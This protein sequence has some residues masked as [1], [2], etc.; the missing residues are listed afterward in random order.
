[1]NTNHVRIEEPTTKRS[2]LARLADLVMHHRRIVAGVWIA[3]TIFGAFSA[4]QVSKRWLE[5]FSIPGFSAYEANQRALQTFGTGAQPP[6]IAVLRVKGDVTKSTAARETLARVSRDFP[7]FRTS[8][9]FTT[10]S[11]AYV[12]RDRHT[13]FATFYPPGRPS[14][15][16]DAGFDD[17][18]AALKKAALPGVETNV[19]GRDALYDSQGS[20][21]GGPS[22]LTEALIGGA[23]ALVIL[24]FV[25]GTLPAML[26]P[27]L[28]AIASILNT[29]TLIW[30]LTYITNVSIIVQ[31][32]VALVGLG[33]AIDYA[34]LMIF[35]FREEL[36]HGRD[37]ETAVVETMTHAGR[38]VIV[39]GSTVAI[40]LLS[41]VIIPIPVI[42]SIGIGGMLIP[43]VSVLVAITMLP[44]L[45]SLVGTRIN[46][47]RVMP[48][49]LVEGTDLEAGFWWRWA[50]LVM[51]R[52]LAIGAVG[53]A[54]VALLLIPSSQLNP[55]EAQAKDL[56]GAK[57]ADAVVGF[58]RLTESGVSPGALRPFDVLVEH[59]PG[60]QALRAVVSRLESTPGLAGASAPP[61]WR[62][63]DAALVEAIPSQDGAA[64]PVR[65]TI[66]NLQND[67][68]P[69]LERQIGGGVQLTLG[70]SAPEDRDFVHA[71]YGKFPYVLAFVILLTFV[72]LMR[73]FR[74][75]FLAVK[76]VILNLISLAAAFGIIVF[77]FQEG[78]GAEA[79]WNVHPTDAI[80]SWIPLM[81]FAFLYGLS[82]DYEV[83]MVS[84]MREAYDE[85][86]KTT[87]SIAAGLARTGKLV[88]SAA[89]VLMFAF[90]V[91][92]TSPGTD[93]K[94][95]GIG[96]AA[97]IIFDATVI[98][99]L[100]VPSIMRVAGRWN[101]WFPHPLA[102]LLF[103]RPRRPE[104]EVAL[105]PS[106][107]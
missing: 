4:Q 98:R 67:V 27:I 90:F 54:I 47:L 102:R 100:L 40:G 41:M 107:G 73:A 78:H 36:R 64:K 82:M 22:V 99:A 88:T 9:Y 70:G 81:I 53:L 28:I 76:A 97:G 103:V 38:S 19:T 75:V 104:V 34:L 68:L 46:S 42:R 95:F 86:G 52:P 66:S 1:M 15:S 51:R 55:A 48:R 3:L 57:T 62:K 18:R 8:S 85:T 83:F 23:G 12:S 87:D 63:G 89:L 69:S 106:G 16:S 11:L 37:V 96:L 26:V 79:I 24:L 84:R 39:S 29:F 21:S 43:A 32:L 35:R 101:W 13:A 105:D 71:V 74:S 45:L 6:N 50:H 10:G 65:S 20:E 30:V 14:F 92:S 33:V 77:I 60:P 5:Q 2:A 61:A 31:F 49:R 25:F 7:Q 80:I 72:L 91:L 44:A 56:A 58:N 17:I 59:N 93:V 94:Q